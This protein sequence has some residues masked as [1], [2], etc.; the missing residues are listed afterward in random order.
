MNV[1]F[2]KSWYQGGIVV[3]GSVSIYADEL[4]KQKLKYDDLPIIAMSRDGRGCKFP[5]HRIK[6]HKCI[7]VF[8]NEV[9]ADAYLNRILIQ[10]REWLDTHGY[11]TAI[12]GG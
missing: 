7:P 4:E 12:T 11:S 5:L 3:R 6:Y 2:Y 1:T 9:D 8:K 10:V